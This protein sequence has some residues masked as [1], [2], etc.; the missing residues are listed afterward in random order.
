MKT[1]LWRGSAI[2]VPLLL[3]GCRAKT[4]APGASPLDALPALPAPTSAPTPTATVAPQTTPQSAAPF[5]VTARATNATVQA[6]APIALEIEIK[7]ATAQ[8]QTL[9]FS[10][11]QSFDFFATRAGET[12]SVWSYGMNKRFIQMLRS[13]TLDAGKSLRF[14]TT[15]NG[16][17]P[18]R[19]TVAGRITAN[20]G[21]DAAPFEVV[22]AP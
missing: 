11:G 18:G 20:G 10:S 3:A 22:V 21:L 7:N 17:A 19:Y 9:E 5:S 14:T 2:L 4:L 6:G 13:Q 1:L 15:W 16:A 8:P 12:E